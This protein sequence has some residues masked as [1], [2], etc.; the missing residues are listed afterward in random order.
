MQ[1]KDCPACTHQV[2]LLA[3]TC[4]QCGH[5]IAE[6]AKLAVAEVELRVKKSKLYHVIGSILILAGLLTI[7]LLGFTMKIRYVG[8]AL[9]TLGLPIYIYGSLASK[10][11]R[12]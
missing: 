8:A 10:W 6:P 9:A 3:L 7:F 2:S 11:H 1:L 12:T 5:P 4:P